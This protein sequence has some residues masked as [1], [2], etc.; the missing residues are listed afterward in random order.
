MPPYL[1]WVM[2]AKLITE[3]D[4]ADWYFSPWCLV[5]FREIN[6]TDGTVFCSGED[7]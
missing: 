6:V 4:S 5:Y 7:G 1:I 2:V 3:A